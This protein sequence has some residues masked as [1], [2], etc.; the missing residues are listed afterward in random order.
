MHGPTVSP[1]TNARRRW[2]LT[3]LCLVGAFNFIDRQVI[4]V[5][6]VPIQADFGVSDTQLGL[7]TGLLFAGSY[8]LASIPLAALS[9]R[10]P[11]RYVLAGC[12]SVWSVMTAAGGSAAS[13]VQLAMTRV[14]V[15]VAEAGAVPASHS[16]ISDIFPARQR[17]TAIAIFSSVQAIGVGAGIFLGGI[18][19]GVAGWRLT[20]LIVGAP[21]LLL[22]ILLLTVREPTRGMSDDF[23]TTPHAV[24]GPLA[25]I[26]LLARIPAYPWL[27]LLMAS[28]GF[29]GF[30]ILSW[31]PTF[32]HR[33]HGLSLESVG[34]AF[35]GA[36]AVG[37]II[38]NL[39]AG[40]LADR[41]GKQG[42]ENYALVAAL[43]IALA[44]VPGLLFILASQPW[45]AFA[46]LFF[47]QVFLT[48]HLPPAYALGQT[49]APP[50]GRAMSSVLLGLSSSG[51]GG[52]LAPLAIG[53]LSDLF[54][55]SQGAQ[56]LRN[57][58]TATIVA[59]LVAI[60]AATVA[61]IKLKQSRKAMS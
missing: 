18:L 46:G 49:L 28:A 5:L 17:G 9:D 34:A 61:H 14:G 1:W 42:L 30:G 12:L 33:W 52:G 58:L 51:L 10:Y 37:L 36:V 47:F 3:L 54:G 40:P 39:T 48:F 7:L 38:G 45:L 27:C 13:F 16:M 59:A 56:S 32:L 24:D 53:S 22:A 25:T 43:G 50:N 6:I 4:T 35:G 19:V 41:W 2:L 29:S 60:V 26:G 44:I 31:G 20:L 23:Q 15:A 57:A 8:A 11:R 55:S 21:G